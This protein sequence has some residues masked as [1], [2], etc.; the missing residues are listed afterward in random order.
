[1]ETYDEWINWHMCTHMDMLIGARQVTSLI[2]LLFLFYFFFLYFKDV[3]H[4]N[5]GSC[6]AHNTS[7][8]EDDRS[9]FIFI[10][11]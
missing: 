10:S 4:D 3:D 2:Y 1:M 5:T 9:F 8:G 7:Y 6:P 11:K